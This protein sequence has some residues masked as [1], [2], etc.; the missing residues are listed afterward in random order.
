MSSRLNRGISN[1]LFNKPPVP[2]K[3][4]IT[5]NN[6][7]PQF[8]VK[9]TNDK[10][11]YET[12]TNNDDIFLIKSG[13]GSFKLNRGT[14]KEN[15]LEL[16][17]FS[18]VQVKELGPKQTELFKSIVEALK[19][20]YKSK[21]LYVLVL[22]DIHNVFSDVKD[23]KP[24]SVAAFYLGCFSDDEK[25]MDSMGCNPKCTSSLPPPEGTPGYYACDDLVL[26]Y[27]DGLFHSLNDK[28]SKHVYIYMGEDEFEGFTEENVKQ[29][30][31]GKIEKASL[32]YGNPD[33][34]YKEVTSAVLVDDLPM[35]NSDNS[36]NDTES[37]NGAGIVLIIVLIAI[38]I[39]LIVLFYRYYNKKMW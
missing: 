32:I 20:L 31:D 6:K 21:D 27:K 33:G 26:I 28:T 3:K 15:L 4:G 10:I 23:I 2:I 11:T 14:L 17:K 16:K 37:N 22:K 12:D 29:L 24:G 34:S 8:L 9:G 35:E 30:K 25:F 13:E 18:N 38:I 36:N 5:E 19:Y 1:S 39:L 7:S